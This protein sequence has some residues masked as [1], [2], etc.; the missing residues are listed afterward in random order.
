MTTALSPAVTFD[1]HDA[2][3]SLPACDWCGAVVHQD[4]VHSDLDVCTACGL[5]RVRSQ[6][7]AAVAPDTREALAAYAHEAWS[8]WMR[9]LFSKCTRY[10]YYDDHSGAIIPGWAVERWQRQMDTPYADLPEEEKVSD[11]AEADKMLAL[12]PKAAAAT[13]D[14]AIRTFVAEHLHL[15]QER[16]DMSDA[17]CAAEMAALDKVLGQT[18]KVK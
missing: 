6:R 18:E 9:Y 15:L 12:M 16:A 13:R 11:R 7:Q 1:S 2:P 17:W 5:H 10:N 14:D 4:A 3:P 8:G